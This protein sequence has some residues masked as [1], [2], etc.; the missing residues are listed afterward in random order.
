MSEYTIASTYGTGIFK[1][2][3]VKLVGGGGIE[4]AAAADRVL[5]VFAGCQYVDA[6]GNQVFS[7]YWP[8][9]TVAT[10]IVA[11]VYDDP[12]IVFAAQQETGGTI[13]AADVGL[14]GDH[15]AGAGDTST[16]ISRHEFEATVGTGNA[17]FRFHGIL[18]SPGNAYGEHANVLV[19]I[20]EHE[21][22][23]DDST[24][25]GV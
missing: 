18:K 12:N 19:T 10:E 2:D 24:T 17:A 14:L 21:F 11:W 5:G 22:S 3:V 1:G 16:G 20:F 9:S 6:A 13:A 23:R 25:P 15:V 7:K 4:A 8:A